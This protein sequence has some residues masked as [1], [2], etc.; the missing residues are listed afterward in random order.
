MTVELESEQEA[1]LTRLREWYSWDE[2]AEMHSHD[3][4]TVAWCKQQDGAT[5][6]KKSDAPNL[7][8]GAPKA[9]GSKKDWVAFAIEQGVD[10]AE[11]EALTRDQ[12]VE[13]FTVQA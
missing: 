9:S 13:H 10:A 11:A 1:R 2:I 6:E 7:P 8:E 4:N 5:P 12:L 3:E